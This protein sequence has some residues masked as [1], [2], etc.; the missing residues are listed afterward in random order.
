M[1][2]LA[3]ALLIISCSPRT[4]KPELSYSTY[5]GSEGKEGSNGEEGTNNW[6]K[7]FSI[8]K[9]GSPDILTTEGAYQ[10]TLKGKTDAI[11]FKISF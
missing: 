6:L 1:G 5:F 4:K 9:A 3:I 2:F 11:I 10:D 7:H 8:D